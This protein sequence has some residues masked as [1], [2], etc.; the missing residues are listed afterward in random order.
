MKLGGILLKLDF[1]KAYDRVNWDFL[2]EVLRG[3]GFEEGY[4]HRIS[5]LVAGGQTAI[6]INGV[7]GPFFRNKR[8][9]RQGD[10]LSPLLFNFIGEALSAILSAAGRA[11]HI[12]GVVPHLI[13]GGIS[14]LQYADDTLILIQNSDEDIANLK[15]LVMC[16]ED[17]SGLKINYH[18]SEVIVMGQPTRVQNQVA[19]KLNCKLGSFPFI[20]LGMPIS[21]RKL[22][23][24]Q[25]LFLDGNRTSFWLDWWLDSRPLNELFPLL[26]AICDDESVSV[27]NALQ[28][29]GLAIR[30]RRSLDQEGTI[31]WRNLCALVEGVVLSPGLDQIRWHLDSSGSF[32]VKSL[33]FKLS[34]GTSV[35]HFKDMW[36]SKVPLKIKI[37]SW[38]LPLDKLPSNLQIATR[39]GPSTGGCALCGAPEDASHIFFTC[40]LAQ[41][42]WAVLRQLLECNWRPAN[43]PQFHAILSG[44]AGYS[45]RILWVLF[46]AQSWALWT[47]RNKLTIDRKIINHPADFIYKFVIFLQLWRPKFKGMEKE[48]LCWMERKLRELYASM[49]PRD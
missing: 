17:M 36:E 25:W 39:H 5:Q 2:A 13:P 37:F 46:L 45:R 4:I 18:K 29:E 28:G 35:A 49:K 32:S 6:S 31:Q 20:Y 43:F 21:D 3:K 23:L 47:I 33:Y 12:H 42:A 19:N 10:P 38:Q 30:F 7:I 14:H 27:A 16:F 11:G 41:F 24:E 9:V 15:F 34:Q 40:S 26:F 44:F 1:E 22:T 48:G 8:G